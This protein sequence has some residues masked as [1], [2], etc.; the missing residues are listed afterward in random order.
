MLSEKAKSRAQQ[1][2]FGIVRSYQKGELENPSPEV[3]KIAST[4][5]KSDVKKMASTKHEGLPEKKKVEEA[6][7][8]ASLGKMA[9]SKGKGMVKQKAK[10]VVK[11][12]AANVAQGSIPQ[13]NRDQVQEGAGRAAIGAGLGAV[14][15]GPVG[16]AIGGSIGAVMGKKKKKVTVGGKKVNKKATNF[17]KAEPKITSSEGVVAFVKKGLERDKKAKVE[18]KIKNR[19]AVPYAALGAS[20]QPE[21]EIVEGSAY[22]LWKGDGKRKLPGDKKNKDVKEA[23]MESGYISNAAKAEVRNERRFGKKGS[24]TPTGTFGQGTSEKAQLAV[25]RGQEH[26]AKRNVK[27]RGVKEEVLDEAAPLAAVPAAAAKGVAVAGKVA[28]KGAAM[29]GKALA[30]G[31]QVAGKAASSAAKAAK[32]IV[33]SGLKAA[34]KGTKAVAKSAGEGIKAGAKTAGQTVAAAAGDAGASVIKSAGEGAAQRVKQRIAGSSIAASYEPELSIVDKMV[35]EYS[36]LTELNKRERVEA[37]QGK[38]AAKKGDWSKQKAKTGRRNINRFE[39]GTVKRTESSGGRK[40]SY[41][42]VT[43]PNPKSGYGKKDDHYNKNKLT[44]QR[45][46]AHGTA[47]ATEPGPQKHHSSGIVH[48]DSAQQQRRHE[49][50]KR[51][52]VKTKGTVA[53]DIKKSLKDELSIVDKMLA[54]YLPEAK[55]DDVKY[56]KGKGWDQPEGKSMTSYKARHSYLKKNPPNV[57]SDRNK[58]H[59][60]QDVVFHGHDKVER[61]R[62]KK[63][64]ASQGVKKVRGAK[65]PSGGVEALKKR[66]QDQGAMEQI[67]VLRNLVTERAAKSGGDAALA[68]GN[69]VGKTIGT[70]TGGLVGGLAGGFPGAA[71]GAISGN[72]VGGKLAPGNP[73]KKTIVKVKKEEVSV[74][75]EVGI[76]S[77]AAMEKARK[78][79]QLQA[80]EDAKVA[81]KKKKKVNEA[82]VDAGLSPE[83]KEKARNIRRFGVGHNVAAHGKLRRALERSNRGDKK[84]KGDKS[85]YVETEAYRVLARDKGDKGRPAQFSYKDEDLANKFADSERSKGGKATVAKEGV[86]DIVN[87]YRKKQK[88]EKKPSMDSTTSKLHTLRKEKFKTDKQKEHEKY[89]N[90]L[91]ADD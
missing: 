6:A 57:R 28:V 45:L 59:S 31:A 80:R 24:A 47:S 7:F 84:I 21:G 39:T 37:G 41:K 29:A 63:H 32:P 19:K 54:K 64:H 86:M 51:R 33:K 5:S 76:S 60:E 68:S 48:H 71:V 73:E 61:D 1:K 16:A 43:L 9:M 91:D 78:E 13:P 88:A 27:T 34:A 17:F 70:V 90:F 30:K 81:E 40:P 62:K 85:Q 79:A 18:K 83:E 53:A 74:E 87:R 46:G 72:V 26:E 49:H 11:Q 38:R 20:Y 66:Y 25:K 14:V 15:G 65:T 56:G 82:K 22:G 77:S 23:K 44:T 3:E 10:Q 8:L 35:I 52:G 69:L 50:Q 75:E 12:K 89:V 55:V 42:E 58:R 2:L 4:V 36:P 67:E